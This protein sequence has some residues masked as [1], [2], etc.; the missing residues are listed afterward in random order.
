MSPGVTQLLEHTLSSG[1]FSRLFGYKSASVSNHHLGPLISS[2]NGSEV[3]THLVI[4]Q[5]SRT[6]NLACDKIITLVTCH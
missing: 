1:S 4:I 6:A 3:G 2:F 5:I